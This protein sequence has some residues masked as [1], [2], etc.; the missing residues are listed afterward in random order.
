[1]SVRLS[2]LVSIDVVPTHA[3]ESGRES[4]LHSPQ[5]S[6]RNLPDQLLT[7][8]E[9]RQRHFPIGSE[10]FLSSFDSLN[11]QLNTVKA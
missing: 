3:R 9:T 11:N 4:F 8:A 10:S 6:W 1:M 7:N 2:L 5:R